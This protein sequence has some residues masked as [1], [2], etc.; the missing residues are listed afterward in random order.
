[1]VTQSTV[2]TSTVGSQSYRDR[3][4][5]NGNTSLDLPGS[6]GTQMTNILAAI[7]N[8]SN[9]ALI[10]SKAGAQSRAFA[11]FIALDEAEQSVNSVAVMKFQ[12]VATPALPLKY[13]EIPAFDASILLAGQ[14]FVDPAATQPAIIITNMDAAGWLYIGSYL[15]TRD[16]KSRKQ[17]VV[18]GLE[19][20]EVGTLPSG[21]PDFDNEEGVQ[22]ED[23]EDA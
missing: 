7:N 2:V 20:P 10:K 8:S 4:G 9:A 22:T 13:V 15:T 3:Y 12:N 11:P 18:A 23:P 1:M 19:E 17:I 16:S 21:L 5:Q 6:F 14:P